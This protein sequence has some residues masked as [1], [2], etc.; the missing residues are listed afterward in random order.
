M[1]HI[2]TPPTATALQSTVTAP[3]TK[4]QFLAALRAEYPTT[5][6]VLRAFPSDKGDFRPH[7]RSSTARELAFTLAS[8][9]T[10]VVAAIKGELKMD[11]WP[12]MP[13]VSYDALVQMFEKSCQ[14]L[15]GLMERTPDSR[16]GETTEFM[17]APKLTEQIP[18]SQLAWMALYDHIH[19]RGQLSVY[20]RMA[21]GRVPSIYGPSA[22]EPWT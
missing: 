11:E 21:G 17:T 5:L 10:M 22:D 16:L 13:N 14:D 7:P 19:H 15:I 1:T 3:S 9:Q 4:E 2:A 20:V 12:Q 6:K 18:I 8:D